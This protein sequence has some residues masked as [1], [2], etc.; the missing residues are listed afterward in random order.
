MGKIPMQACHIGWAVVEESPYTCTICLRPVESTV[1]IDRL[2][3]LRT[4]NK[5]LGPLETV[6][7]C[8]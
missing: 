6:K 1:S 5:L 7:L 8:P 4:K 2:S 3:E